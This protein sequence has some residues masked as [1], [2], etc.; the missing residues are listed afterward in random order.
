MLKLDLDTVS[1]TENFR[2][3]DWRRVLEVVHAF[4]KCDFS[5]NCASVKKISTER[6]RRTA[7]LR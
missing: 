6:A 1:F 7:N 3:F 4:Y 2:G 5:Y